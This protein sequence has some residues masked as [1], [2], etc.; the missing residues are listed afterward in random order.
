MSSSESIATPTRPDLAGRQRVIRIVADL[1][2]QVEG[3]RKPGGA[4]RR[5]GTGS[6]VRL[7]GLAKPAY[8][9]IVHSRPRYIVGWMPRV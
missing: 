3:D 1:R 7:F 8:C 2:R 5:A 9:R 4:L 6:A